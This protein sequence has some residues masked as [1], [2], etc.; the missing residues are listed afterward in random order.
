MD[1]HQNDK[2]KYRCGVGVGDREEKRRD[3][4]FS[5][6]FNSFQGDCLPVLL[7]VIFKT[8]FLILN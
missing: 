1:I 5:I 3:F 4:N 8:L 6:G 7:H 2:S